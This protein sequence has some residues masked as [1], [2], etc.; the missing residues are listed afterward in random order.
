MNVKAAITRIRLLYC[1]AGVVMLCSG[2]TIYMFFRNLDIILFRFIPK[3]A[4]L[5]TFFIPVKKDSIAGSVFLF[6]L[7][8]GLWFLSGTLFIRA[9][10]LT[11]AKW[12]NFYFGLFATVALVFETVQIF[13]AVPGT[14]DAL[15]ILFMG[16]FAFMESIIFIMFI[17]RKI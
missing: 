13:P 6:N 8:D 5:D 3:P 12:R 15:D 7:P 4:F 2:I 10:W 17:R 11:N 16:I 1:G 14:F 9:L